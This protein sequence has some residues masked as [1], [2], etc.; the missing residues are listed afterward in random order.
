VVAA[1]DGA[2]AGRGVERRNNPTLAHDADLVLDLHA[3]NEAEPHMYVGP[4]LWPVAEDIA[5]AIDARAV[6]PSEVSGGYPFD[7]ACA[8]PWWAPIK[9]RRCLGDLVGKGDLVATVIDPLG[10]ET[11]LRIDA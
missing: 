1:P 4:A 11:E 3:E 5:A 2:G 8:S 10:E 9:P 6:L 7:E